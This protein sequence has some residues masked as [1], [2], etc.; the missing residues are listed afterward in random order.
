MFKPQNFE[1]RKNSRI[2]QWII[3]RFRSFFS[4]AFSFHVL[5]GFFRSR[6]KYPNRFSGFRY[7]QFH[8]YLPSKSLVNA[9]EIK[10]ELGLARAL[11]PEVAVGAHTFINT[12]ICIG[13]KYWQVAVSQGLFFWLFTPS[14]RIFI[15]HSDLAV[16]SS[17]CPNWPLQPNS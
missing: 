2:S 10:L 16:T 9:P 5:K 12:N 7:F 6:T 17:G 8:L 11:G 1:K 15:L 4:F 13:C 14:F 3:G